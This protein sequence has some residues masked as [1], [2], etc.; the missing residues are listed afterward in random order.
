MAFCKANSRNGFARQELKV[1]RQL[2]TDFQTILLGVARGETRKEVKTMSQL[3]EFQAP[4]PFLT[5]CYI[6]D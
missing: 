4:A 2:K 1:K 5:L 6:G 3:E